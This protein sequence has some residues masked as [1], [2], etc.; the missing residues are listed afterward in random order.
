[1]AMHEKLDHGFLTNYQGYPPLRTIGKK[2]PEFADLTLIADHPAA[3]PALIQLF[4]S[5]TF[6]YYARLESEQVLEE[7][8]VCIISFKSNNNN[9]AVKVCVDFI[10]IPDDMTS[11][12]S[13]YVDICF[14]K[15]SDHVP[16]KVL[17][18]DLENGGEYDLSPDDEFNHDN[19]VALRLALGIAGQVENPAPLM[20]MFLS[21][22]F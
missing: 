21:R 7:R 22:V 15:G 10:L 19:F 8:K 20:A 9:D 14:K 11:L 18:F 16:L 13:A 5:A 6:E 12:F 4:S 3:T 17:S 1:M 2:C